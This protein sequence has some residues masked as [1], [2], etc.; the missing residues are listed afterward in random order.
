MHSNLFTNSVFIEVQVVSVPVPFSHFIDNGAKN[1][2][3]QIF[4]YSVSLKKA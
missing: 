3:E 1:A 2:S 4:I